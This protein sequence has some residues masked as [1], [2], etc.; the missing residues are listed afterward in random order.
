MTTLLQGVMNM[1]VD[2]FTIPDYMTFG[3]AQVT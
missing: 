3:K 1:D 2:N